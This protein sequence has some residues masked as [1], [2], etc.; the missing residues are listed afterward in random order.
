MSFV[1]NLLSCDWYAA[2]LLGVRDPEET[3]ATLAVAL[4]GGQEITLGRGAFNRPYSFEIERPQ[5]SLK[6]FG[7]AGQDVFI[8]ATGAAA[9]LGHLTIRALWP[10][11][12]V[13]RIDVAAD[14]DQLG[15]YDRL[16]PL[17]HGVAVGFKPNPVT[18]HEQGDWVDADGALM[19]GEGGAGRTLYLGS[20]KGATQL[21]LYQ[22]GHEQ[23]AKHPDQTFSLGWVRAEVQHRPK[24]RAK[25]V[26][27]SLTLPQAFGVA[28]FT[29]AAAEVLGLDSAPPVVAPVSLATDTDYWHYRHYGKYIRRALAGTPDECFRYFADL[30]ARYGTPEPVSEPGPASSLRLGDDAPELVLS[31]E[32][33]GSRS[34]TRQ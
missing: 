19:T 3:S 27:A 11:H 7:G 34:D 17:L 24:S 5:G 1:E 26:A 31:S 23:T 22:K 12:L 18:T 14:Y 29:R 28:P 25:A 2:C 6:V 15:L 16:W 4:G 33:K 9:Q 32:G 20:S 21:R 10:K 8:Q 13:S 30:H